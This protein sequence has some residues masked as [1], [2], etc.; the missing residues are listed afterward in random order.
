MPTP[1]RGR[2]EPQITDIQTF[3]S[4][5]LSQPEAYPDE[6]KS[7]L[8]NFIQQNPNLL[9]DVSQLPSI[10][11]SKLTIPNAS[12]PGHLLTMNPGTSPP[13]SPADGDLWLYTGSGFDWLFV[14]DS[15]ETT[16]KWKFVGGPHLRAEV[17]ANETYNSASYGDPTTAGPSITLPRAGDYETG[18]GCSVNSTV[19]TADLLRASPSIAGAT[20]TDANGV[21]FA[22]SADAGGVNRGTNLYRSLTMA[23]RSASD[24]LKLQY[25]RV[26]GTFNV[27]RRFIE[28]LPIRVI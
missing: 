20:P 17:N 5:W 19:T 26:N 24:V 22:F 18:F 28:A 1:N 25:K 16:Y 11:Y 6:L 23:G 15:A 13:A 27:D 12:I 8:I 9:L 3:L 21:F 4:R 10:P 2:G 7:W 14:Y